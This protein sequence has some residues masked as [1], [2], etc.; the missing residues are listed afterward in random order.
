MG[1]HGVN[2]NII[3]VGPTPILYIYSLKHFLTTKGALIEGD[4]YPPKN[5]KNDPKNELKMSDF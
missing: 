1:P 4:G 2:M 3:G 5:P